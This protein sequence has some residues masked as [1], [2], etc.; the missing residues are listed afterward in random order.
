MTDMNHPDGN[1]LLVENF[2]PEHRSLRVALVTETYPPEVNGVALTIDRLVRGLQARHHDIQLIRPRQAAVDAPSSQLSPEPQEQLLM[3]GLPIPRYPHLRMGMP[4]KRALLG[5]WS[6]R[7][8]DLVHIATEGPLGWSALQAARKLRLPVSSDF[9]TNFHSYSRHYGIGW[10]RKPI[11]AYLRRF[12]NQAQCTMV[13]TASLQQELGKLGFERLLVVARGVDTQRFDPVRRSQALRQA[14]G[15]REGEQVV[16]SVGRIAPEKNLDL[17]LR[18]VAAMRLVNPALRLVVVGDG[19]G[20]AALQQHC[21]DAVLAGSRS[22]I[23]LAEH[24]ASADIFLFPSLTETYGNVT[25]EALAS[26]L[27][28]LAY[29]YAAA[30]ELIR[31]GENGLLAPQGDDDAFVRRAID[32]AASPQLVERLR[33]S[34]RQSTQALDWNRICIQVESIWHQLIEQQ[35]Q[36]AA[37][38]RPAAVE[39]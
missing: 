20:R 24:Y 10:L 21:P 9:R 12:H 31:H 3:R 5:H 15:I 29:D 19:P 17:L 1:P 14:W 37:G 16:L 32:L 27:A 38:L 39:A 13:P 8:P 22:G 34:A 26:G 35:L 11:A 23:D 2:L 25:P 36:V 4:A 30:A 18:S 33:H 7:R 28:V 6:L